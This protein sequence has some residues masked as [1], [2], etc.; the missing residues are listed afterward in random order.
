MHPD[1]TII[2][3]GG[4]LTADKL[5]PH[6]DQR[7]VFLAYG[8]GHLSQQITQAVAEQFPQAQRLLPDKGKDW[9]ECWRL[10]IED[11]ERQKAQP[12]NQ[13]KERIRPRAQAMTADWGR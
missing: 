12:L 9:N 11:A 10:Q 8:T 5:K 4:Y 13:A 7:A 1:S 6:L 2:A 3:T